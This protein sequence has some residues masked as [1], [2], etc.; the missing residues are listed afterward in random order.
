MNNFYVKEER[1]VIWKQVQSDS[2]RFSQFKE[3]N[4]DE[5]EKKEVNQDTRKALK[6]LREI[7]YLEFKTILTPEEQ[8]K[9]ANKRKWQ[10]ILG[11][12]QEEIEENEDEQ[13]RKAFEK[14][15]LILEQK[16]ATT[17]AHDIRSR[18]KREVIAQKKKNEEKRKR[19]CKEREMLFRAENYRRYKSRTV[20]ELEKEW[21]FSLAHMYNND[22]S[23]TFHF[24]SIKYHPDKCYHQDAH[25]QKPLGLLRCLPI[26]TK[27]N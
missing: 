25:L 23:K 8:Q 10:N 15:L 13:A 1:N 5:D 21:K 19:E 14:E 9:V 20:A 11:I 12:P 4:L 17:K 16:E 27:P 3:V 6:K 7:E 26:P 2:N 22:V 18:Q 24:M